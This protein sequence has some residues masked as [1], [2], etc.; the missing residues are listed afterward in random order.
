[1]SKSEYSTLGVTNDLKR[2]RIFV[3]WT[4]HPG[5]C[6]IP[7]CLQDE[8]R[9]EGLYRYM[10]N[11]YTDVQSLLITCS[12]LALGVDITVM[13]CAQCWRQINLSIDVVWCWFLGRKEC[14]HWYGVWPD[15]WISSWNTTGRHLLEPINWSPQHSTMSCVCDTDAACV[16]RLGCVTARHSTSGRQPNFVALN[17]GRHPYSAELPS[18]WALAH[19][20]SSY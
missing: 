20:S 8:C 12:S 1:V 16:S 3:V 19:I 13:Q 17:R 11:L 6:A 18:R 10:Y 5:Q 2:C 14:H 4:S 7:E 15:C 9:A